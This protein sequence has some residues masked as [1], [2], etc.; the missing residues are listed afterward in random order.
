HREASDP[1]AYPEH[2][3][4]PALACGLIRQ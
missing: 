3:A 4:G 2:G 1:Y